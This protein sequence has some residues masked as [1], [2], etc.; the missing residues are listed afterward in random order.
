MDCKSRELPSY[1]YRE[2]CG[3]RNDRGRTGG[4]PERDFICK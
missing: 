1:F 2:T 4:I 3:F